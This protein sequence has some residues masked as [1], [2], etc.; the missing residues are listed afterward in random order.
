M[1]VLEASALAR[2]VD[3]MKKKSAG[4]ARRYARYRRRLEQQAAARGHRS[5]PKPARVPER[6]GWASMGGYMP[7]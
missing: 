5:M 1:P 6:R 7:W 2:T 4:W 3:G